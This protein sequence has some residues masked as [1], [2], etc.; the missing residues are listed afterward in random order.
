[1]IIVAASGDNDSSDGGPT[2]ANVDFPAS[3]PYVIGCGGTSRVK[4]P[5]SGQSVETVWNNNPGHADGQGTGGGFS[6]LFP[7][8]DWQLGSVQ[9]RM[10]M[11]PDIAAHA[12]PLTGYRIFVGGQPRV[13]G[14]T[15]AATALYAGLFAAFGPKRGFITPDL[16]KNQVCFNDIRGGD[17]GMFRA[18]VGPD[19]CTGIGSPRAD[20]L[21]TR[22]GSDAATLKRVRRQG[23]EASGPCLCQSTTYPRTPSMLTPRVAAAQMSCNGWVVPGSNPPSKQGAINRIVQLSDNKSSGSDPA[24]PIIPNLMVSGG[25]AIWLL[26]GRCMNDSY[27]PGLHMK[28]EVDDLGTTL[29]TFA[30]YILCCYQHRPPQGF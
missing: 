25:D 19:P 29:G 13:I 28:M 23:K 12:D 10:R 20:L 2:P 1:M 4:A 3:S 22:I 6:E 9:A 27:F 16:Y 14:G 30:D 7:I 17:N 15:S 5:K 26:A 8:E 21:A 24:T 11:V 18:M